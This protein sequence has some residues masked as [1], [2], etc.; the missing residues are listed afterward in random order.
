MNTATL[1]ADYT[2]LINESIKD[3]PRP[4]LTI[5]THVCR[6]NFRST[7]ISSAATSRWRR[8]ARPVQF[9]GY[10]LEYDSERGRRL[11]AA[12]F[13]AEW[14]PRFVVVGVIT[15]ETPTLES[16]DYGEA[17]YRRGRPEVRAARSIWHPSARKRS[18]SKP[19]ARSESY[20]RK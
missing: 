14:V 3:K 12:A 7:W 1:A 17:P 2:R 20:S 19:P 5:T 18:G 13:P 16:K 15:F 8:A 6:G 11:R 9:D 4:T 10:F